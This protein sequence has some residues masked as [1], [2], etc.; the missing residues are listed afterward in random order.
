MTPRGLETALQRVCRLVRARDGEH[1]SDGQLLLRFRLDHDQGAFEDLLGRHGP[2]VLAVCRRLLRNAADAED[3]FQATFLVL[4]RKAGSIR[5]QESVGSWLYGVA[6]RTA[7]RA[8]AVAERRGACE[9]ARGDL[10]Q[11]PARPEAARDD[12]RAVLD[13]ELG[14]LPERLRAP[15]VLCYLEGKTNEEAAALLRWPVG[16]VKGRLYRAR[17][18]LRGR[19]ARRGLALSAAAVAAALAAGQAPA[20][21]PPAL[22]LSA[23]HAALPTAAAGT[24]PANVAT[25]AQG[26]LNDMSLAKT[27]CGAALLLTVA[28]AGAGLGWG[29]YQSRAA[30]DA[31]AAGA[32]EGRPFVPADAFGDPLPPG[33]V[34]RMGT[35]RLRHG[36]RVTSLAFSSSEGNALLVSAGEDGTIRVWEPATGKAVRRLTG[37]EAGDTI[38]LALA[39][40]NK[41]LASAGRADPT[42]RLWDVTTGKALGTLGERPAAG[43]GAFGGGVGFVGGPAGGFV[44]MAPPALTFS[45]DGKTLAAV[46]TGIRQQAVGGVMLGNMGATVV[47][48][49]VAG[50]KELRRLE[51]PGN[52]ADVPCLAFSPDGRRLAAGVNAFNLQFGPGVGGP[53]V[54]PGGGA[55]GFAGGGVRP[56]P[57]ARPGGGA[58]AGGFGGAVGAGGFGG[59]IGVAGFG[60]GAPGMP[61]GGLGGPG[62]PNFSRDYTLFVWD[63][64]SGKE[65][66]RLKG[67]K[68]RVDAVAFHPA[69][70]SLAAACDESPAVLGFQ[71]GPG[72]VRVWNPGT[73]R[74]VRSFKVSRTGAVALAF[75]ADGKNLATGSWDGFALWRYDTGTLV[76]RVPVSLGFGGRL[77]CL[78][79]SADGKTVAAAVNHA[80]RLWDAAGGKEVRPGAGHTGAVLHLHYSAD[81]RALLSSSGDGLVCLWEAASGKQRST[82][83]GGQFAGVASLSP[84]GELVAAAGSTGPLHLWDAATGKKL[85]QVGP[86]DVMAVYSSA[87]SA[88]GTRL[89]LAY[90][91]KDNQ[92]APTRL[93]VWDV[94]ANKKVREVTVKNAV[95]LSEVAFAP[96]GKT[97]AVRD[98]LAGGV[99]ILDLAKGQ[100]VQHLGPKVQLGA[101]GFGMI[102]PGGLQAMGFGSPFG[103]PC[104]AFAQD[105]SALAVGHARPLLFGGAGLLGGAGLAGGGGGIGGGILG[106]PAGA[107]KDEAGVVLWQPATGKELVRLAKGADVRALAVSPDGRTVAVADGR[108]PAVRLWE[109]AT[110]KSRGEYRL[111]QAAVTSLR[112]TPDGRALASGSA[113][114][115]V[116]VRDL[117]VPLQG[118]GPAAD[119]EGARERARL[120]DE[121]RGDDAARAFTAMGLFRRSP[122]AVPFLKEQLGR[123]KPPDPGRAARLI[124]DL[125][126]VSFAKR[127]QA[128]KELQELGSEAEPLLRRA[129]ADNA[130]SVEVHRRAERLL[131]EMTLSADT[132]AAM[133]GVE[134]LERLGTAEA[135]RLLAGLA[136]GPA[137]AV[138]TREARASLA[139]LR[140]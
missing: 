100:E 13:E 108:T 12:V 64:A 114:T 47:L 130:V 36:G 62:M 111:H 42:V 6:Y 22:A 116:L 65:V 14:R 52:G 137:D 120:W 107:G 75:S 71:A 89:A 106:V 8:R 125:D 112:F 4:V 90:L 41:T 115:T 10:S 102:G 85:R 80:I 53:G 28:L 86:A 118:G 74:E 21:V 131:A 56:G 2:M 127:Q 50:R 117:S 68:G 7:R 32:P 96:D 55:V 92:A 15:L 132:R 136:R 91:A 73:G 82:F 49:D 57:G 33:V 121:L 88:D 105:G 78:A 26:V 79:F 123:L 76:R 34:A 98:G 109:V 44:G 138:L 25:L 46:Q 135:R 5:K 9:P 139:R 29:A 77:A 70:K 113:D 103:P 18:M 17:D 87:F 16:T 110:G 101:G 104:L 3:A 23:F 95:G 45:P 24:V 54:R 99:Q 97:V 63:V 66:R 124:A 11:V 35:A 1:A 129:L 19:L 140:P 60:G 30:Q 40:D 134:V 72:V 39:S 51:I 59:G 81:G 122:G 67:H 61:G 94:K 128:T 48:Y 133:R 37:H 84:D 83:P 27:I 119:L 31:P 38:S 43:A 69:G 20:A 93:V 58:I 126:S